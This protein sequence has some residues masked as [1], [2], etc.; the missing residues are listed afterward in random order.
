MTLISSPVSAKELQK[1]TFGG[2]CFWCIEAVFDQIEGV[3]EAVSGY[4]G[5]KPNDAN[6][7][8]VS[9]GATKHIECVQVTFDS[10]MIDLETILDWFWRS[11]DPTQKNRQGNDV[12]YRYQS[13]IFYHTAEQKEIVLK[14]KEQ[15]QIRYDAPLTTLVFDAS[16]F[17]Q[18]ESYHQDYYQKNKDSNA[19]C[20][21]VIRPK[22][23]K[24]DLKE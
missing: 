7:K 20:S 2:G 3:K 16:E 4:M 17:H 18:A 6:Y 1:I 23:K 19:Y 13:A 5:G 12:G 11:H 10:E 21:L 8:Q 22:L 15:E 24:L 9:R 14:S